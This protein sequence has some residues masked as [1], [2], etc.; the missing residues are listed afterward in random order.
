MYYKK[1]MLKGAF[2]ECSEA[3]IVFTCSEICAHLLVTNIL[4]AIA[5]HDTWIWH[6]FL[7][8]QGCAMT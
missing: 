6:T 1:K 3:L 7:E 5:T 2:L 4:E 8:C